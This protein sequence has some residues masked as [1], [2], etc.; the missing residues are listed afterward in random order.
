MRT[1]QSAAG[2]CPRVPPAVWNRPCWAVTHWLTD[3]TLRLLC[4]RPDAS[5]REDHGPHEGP[6]AGGA[7]HLQPHQGRS[8]QAAGTWSDS[9]LLWWQSLVMRSLDLQCFLFVCLLFVC[10]LLDWTKSCLLSSRSSQT[11]TWH[12]ASFP[13]M[14]SAAPRVTVSPSNRDTRH[15]QSSGWISIHTSSFQISPLYQ[16]LNGIIFEFSFTQDAFEFVVNF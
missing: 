10:F 6:R 3:W 14:G 16:H 13:S 4:L 8:L 11:S 1:I 12:W 5:V 2:F 9:T 15:H 7:D